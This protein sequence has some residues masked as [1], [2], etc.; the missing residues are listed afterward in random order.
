MTIPAER[1]LDSEGKSAL[2]IIRL[3]PLGRKGNAEKS[4]EEPTDMMGRIGVAN[5]THKGWT[6]S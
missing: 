1:F 6:L 5:V 4:S 3:H 2:V